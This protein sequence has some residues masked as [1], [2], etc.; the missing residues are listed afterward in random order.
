[1]PRPRADSTREAASPCLGT[2]DAEVRNAVE[3]LQV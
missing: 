3:A 2:A 1:M